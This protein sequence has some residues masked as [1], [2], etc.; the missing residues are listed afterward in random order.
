MEAPWLEVELEQRLPADITAT[1]MRDPSRV[2]DLQLTATLDPQ[3]AERG[4]G[5]NPHPHGSYLGSLTTEL[6]RGL[7]ENVFYLC[8]AIWQSLA[9]HSY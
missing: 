4:Q 8:C 7:S 1:A 2:C 3:P 5:W 6:R 9:I